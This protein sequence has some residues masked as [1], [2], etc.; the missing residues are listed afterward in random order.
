MR[1]AEA[2]LL[3]RRSDLVIVFTIRLHGQG[4]ALADLSYLGVGRW[5][6]ER[7]SRR[8]PRPPPA[9]TVPEIGHRP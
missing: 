1:T 5:S 4:Y 6:G 8:P 3:A 2:A 9:T 7:W